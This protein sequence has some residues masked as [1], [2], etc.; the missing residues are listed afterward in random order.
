MKEYN[1]ISDGANMYYQSTLVYKLGKK[2][3]RR[4]NRKEKIKRIWMKN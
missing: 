4:T 3:L 2:I 1:M